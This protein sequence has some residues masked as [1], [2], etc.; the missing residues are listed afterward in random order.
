MFRLFHE[1]PNISHGH[2][3]AVCALYTLKTTS[4]CSLCM[5]LWPVIHWKNKVLAS[6]DVYVFYYI[7]VYHQYWYW[8]L[9]IWNF[10]VLQI[11][12]ILTENIF[13]FN[14]NKENCIKNINISINFFFF[15]LQWNNCHQISE[16]YQISNMSW[17]QI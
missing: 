17:K 1:P 16:I 8:K 13:L 9:N 3:L 11:P 2:R 7:R 5:T 12:S 4:I 6:N 15:P 10:E 14:L